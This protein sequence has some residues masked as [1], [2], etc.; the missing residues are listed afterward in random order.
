MV[1]GII[2]ENNPQ[3]NKGDLKKISALKQVYGRRFVAESLE[4]FLE[5]NLSSLYVIQT[6]SDDDT[7]AIQNVH[8]EKSKV[9]DRNFENDLRKVVNEFNQSLGAKF[10]RVKKKSAKDFRLV[11]SDREKLEIFNKDTRV[12][13]I[14]LAKTNMQDLDRDISRVMISRFC[15]GF[16]KKNF[17]NIKI[18]GMSKEKGVI[19]QIQNSKGFDDLRSH[20]K[21]LN[22]DSNTS[23][24]I[25]VYRLSPTKVAKKF[26]PNCYHLCFM[27]T[28]GNEGLKKFKT[29]FYASGTESLPCIELIK[30]LKSLIDDVNKISNSIQ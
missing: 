15:N 23:N 12:K 13:A 2:S 30:E 26:G 29:E 11:I 3:L 18:V 1:P 10:I 14:N 9:I 6:I 16:L 19:L 8:T 24:R 20:L 5:K 21:K 17:D 22:D 4:L 25:G 27:P 28:E 7:Q